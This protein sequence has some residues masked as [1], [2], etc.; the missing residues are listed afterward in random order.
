MKNH[1]NKSNDWTPQGQKKPSPFGPRPFTNEQA[2]DT[3]P[4]QTENA[5]EQPLLGPGWDLTTQFAQGSLSSEPP[6]MA[7]EGIPGQ[8]L[9]AKLTVG[10][11]DDKYER[12]ADRVAARVV[13]QIHSGGV[14]QPLVQSEEQLSRKPEMRQVPGVQRSLLEGGEVSADIESAINRSRGSGQPLDAGLQATMGQ[15]MGADFS[16][17]RVHT[18]AQADALNQSIQAKAFTTGQDVFFRQGEYQPGSRGG[19]ELIAHELTHVV[20]Q[21]ASAIHRRTNLQQSDVLQQNCLGLQEESTA[22]AASDSNHGEEKR[23]VQVGVD[24]ETGAPFVQMKRTKENVKTTEGMDEAS[25][26]KA[27]KDYDKSLISGEKLKTK[28]LNW[29]Q[30]K[31]NAIPP[32]TNEETNEEIRGKGYKTFWQIDGKKVL[33][34]TQRGQEVADLKEG[35]VD[36]LKNTFDVEDLGTEVM[37]YNV[38]DGGQGVLHA[39][40]NWG[41]ADDA[42]AERDGLTAR[43]KNSEIFWYQYLTAREVYQSKVGVAAAS[44]SSIRRSQISND[45][46]LNTIKFCDDWPKAKEKGSVKIIDPTKQDAWALLGTPNGNSSV[47]VLMQH[48]S[49]FEGVD[50]LSVTYETNDKGKGHTYLTIEY[51]TE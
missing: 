12:E 1:L 13:D 48:G 36:S 44:L 4:S 51:V 47:W 50:I 19:Q 17:V 9:Q 2:Q 43:V 25:A 32:K 18:G 30:K 29:Y 10:A 39:Y 21:G 46:T 6:P 27:E 5:A 14:G 41:N 31:N 16:Q 40:G 3:Q 7:F 24:L 35:Q 23:A 38:Y 8:P 37:Y 49:E 22:T 15:A 20:Q 33:I 42:V 26:A 11:A 28:G 45:E 34:V